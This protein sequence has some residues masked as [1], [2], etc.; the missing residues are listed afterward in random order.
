[1]DGTRKMALRGVILLDAPSTH[2]L[3][4]NL[5]IL[6]RMMEYRRGGVFISVDRPH[7]Y[8]VHM[9]RSHRM[10]PAEIT[11]VDLI[12]R[13]ASDSKDM[14]FGSGVEGVPFRI[15]T[16]SELIA[17]LLDQRE[18]GSL[19]ER[20]CM[21]AMVDNLAAF[22]LFNG[23]LRMEAF[24]QGLIDIARVREGMVLPVVIDR[25]QNRGL[26]SLVKGYCDL[27]LG[28]NDVLANDGPTFLHGRW[29]RA[30]GVS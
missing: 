25:Q 18:Q 27:E 30:P 12:G 16:L 20:G 9:M 19:T 4:I 23:R 17:E 2:I 11:F 10:D 1:M 5:L 3:P 13:F 26:Y 29:W 8:M 15:D 21:F 28:I 24:L 7:Q 6:R 14:G 22:Q